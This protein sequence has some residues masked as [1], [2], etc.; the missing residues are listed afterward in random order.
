VAG[1]RD[2][3]RKDSSFFQRRSRGLGAEVRN[4]AVLSADHR[5]AVELLALT[6]VV[7]EQVDTRRA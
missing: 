5:Y 4:D 2:H 6:D 3:N 7:A 1:A